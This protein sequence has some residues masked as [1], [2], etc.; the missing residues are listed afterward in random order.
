MA[1]GGES[2][3]GAP[4]RGEPGRGEPPRAKSSGA[5][6]SVL[7]GE[8]LSYDP[9]EERYWERGSLRS[10]LDRVFDICHGCRMCFKYC[11]TFKDL[12]RIIDEARDGD[13]RSLT[14]GEQ[15][16]VLSGCFQCKQC[17]FACPYTPGKGHEF[18][19]DF[20]NL[21]HRHAAVRRREQPPTGRAALRDALLTNPD[22]T[23][24]LQ[25]L[26][27]AFAASLQNTRPA[28]YCMEKLVGIHREKLLPP[29]AAE[30]FDGWAGRRRPAPKPAGEQEA[31]LFPT[32]YVQNN[33]PQIGKDTLAVLDEN[34]VGTDCVPGLG[35]CGMPSWE[36]G[37]LEAVRRAARKNL[38]L[39]SPFVEAGALVIAVNPTCSMLMRKDYPVLAAP[40]DK[41][42]AGA[43]AAAVRDPSEHLWSIRREPRFS[44]RFRSTPDGRVAYHAPCH[45]RAQGVG[46]RARDLIR[47]IPGVTPISTL[48]CSGH[49]GTWAMK[50]EGFAASRAA[51]RKAFDSMQEADAEVWATDC[52]LAAIQFEQHAG[53]KPLHSMTVLA[54][55]YREDGF[56]TPLPPPRETKEAPGRPAA[57]SPA[58]ET[59][60]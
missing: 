58:R 33:E 25:R 47:K 18:Q 57:V 26:T 48:E 40:E 15:E 27:P 60:P 19:L 49:D 24:S 5:P 44:T 21:V 32:C 53:K 23:G 59:A 39:L 36:S 14:A 10:E 52:P 43:L 30:S 41:E 51:G 20:P 8:D 6:P 2:G 11:D 4:G 34:R 31:V 38:D 37:D 55:A 28:R 7:P 13:P 42:R 1:P 17:E 45:L 46:F 29:F 12:F 35:C 3:R 50:T 56:E 9:G 54:R 16:T 22:R